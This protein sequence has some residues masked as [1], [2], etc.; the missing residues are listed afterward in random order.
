MDELHYEDPWPLH[1]HV[2]TRRTA[3][4]DPLDLMRS[5]ISAYKDWQCNPTAAHEAALDAAIRTANRYAQETEDRLCAGTT[6][7]TPPRNG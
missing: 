3:M 1:G 7:T 6:P 2:S 5:I 4:P